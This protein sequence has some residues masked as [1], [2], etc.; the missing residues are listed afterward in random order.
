MR[1]QTDLFGRM[2][3]LVLWQLV[4]TLTKTNE[5]CFGKIIRDV[6][7]YTEQ[8]RIKLINF[9]KDFFSGLVCK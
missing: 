4:I 8:I 9:V 2:A 6:F 3:F 7:E 5:I 1:W